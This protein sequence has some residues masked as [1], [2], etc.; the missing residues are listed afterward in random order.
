MQKSPGQPVLH[1]TGCPSEV[2][3]VTKVVGK[4]DNGEDALVVT[5][6]L[7]EGLTPAGDVVR[8]VVE[9]IEGVVAVAELPGKRL[10]V[11]FNLRQ[12]QVSTVI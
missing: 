9:V 10:V 5:L 1:G 11:V 7:D 8:G 6:V 4:E 2:Y 12:E 3:V